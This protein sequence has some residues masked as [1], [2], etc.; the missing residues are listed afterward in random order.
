MSSCAN[1]LNPFGNSVLDVMNSSTKEDI[2]KKELDV[3][4]IQISISPDRQNLHQTHEIVI[5]INSQNN[6][7]EINFS[8]LSIFWNDQLVT[9]GLKN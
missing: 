2:F 5:N 7:N 4:D 1:P 9:E 8:N 3:N 6:E